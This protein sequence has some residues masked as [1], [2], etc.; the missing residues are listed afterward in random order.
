MFG[1]TLVIKLEL[2]NE[3]NVAPP[4]V[5]TSY[6]YGLHLNIRGGIANPAPLGDLLLFDDRMGWVNR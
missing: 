6:D 2:G 3:H 4:V 1:F 5:G